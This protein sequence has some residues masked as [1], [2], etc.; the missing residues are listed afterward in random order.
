MAAKKKA[1]PRK[2]KAAAPKKKA[3]KKKWVPSKTYGK[4][5]PLKKLK[6]VE[7]LQKKWS[8]FQAAESVGIS[9]STLNNHRN[10][11]PEF[12]EAIE[13]AHQLYVDE[14]HAELR[15]R[16]VEGWDE[17]VFYLGQ[18]VDTIRKWSDA[19][20]LAELRKHDHDYRETK[21][22]KQETKHSGGVRLPDL[23]SLS[24]KALKA[25]QALLEDD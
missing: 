1:S 23:K 14:L 22:V 5:T 24:P 18:R 10:K 4:M 21:N 3:A 7:F 11:D 19:L 16:G 13:D 8:V 25:A 20:F 6:I 9:Y 2:K 12:A 17:P 15:R